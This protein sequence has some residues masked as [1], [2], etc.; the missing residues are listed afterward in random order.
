[1]FSQFL[2]TV[3]SSGEAINALDD[4]FAHSPFANGNDSS[5]A[6]IGFQRCKA[7]WFKMRCV[8]E[9]GRFTHCGIEL[10]I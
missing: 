8:Q 5:A 4:G 10:L 9:A 2:G 7:K 3:V 6:C 1:M